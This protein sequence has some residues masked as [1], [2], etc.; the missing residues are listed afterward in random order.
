MSVKFSSSLNRGIGAKWHVETVGKVLRLIKWR[1]F[2]LD[3]VKGYS[4]PLGRVK[5][6]LRR[7]GRR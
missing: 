4:S 1:S 7:C 3:V 6:Y 2:H 5:R